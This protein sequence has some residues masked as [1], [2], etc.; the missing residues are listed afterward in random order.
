MP[1]H[2]PPAPS[3]PLPHRRGSDS[4]TNN[5]PPVWSINHSVGPQPAPLP[6]KC[7][8]HEPNR[9]GVCCK[10]LKGDDER[11]LID[12]DVVRDVVIGLSD[13]LTVP[14]ALTAGLSSLGESKLVILGGIAELIAGAISMGIGG[15][16]ATQAERDHYRY[17][18]KVTAARVLRSCDGEMEREVHAVLGPVG[19]D[20]KVS[21]QVASC[22]REVEFNSSVPS[23]EAESSSTRRAGRAST[24]SDATLISE[25]GGEL[26]WSQ[27]VGLTAFLLKFGEGLEDV[28]T[29]RMYTSAFTIG[30]GYLI[31]GLIPLLPYF[32]EP[33]AHIALIYSCVVTGVVLLIFG[34]VKA[35]VTGA[36][37]ANAGGYVWG[38][39][40]TLLVGGAAAAASYGIVAA[41]EG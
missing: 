34:A 23:D 17:L 10:E 12:P 25:E 5:K 1:E 4:L 33:V 22:L 41:L 37:G 2:T 21:R 32:F 36:A 40:S 28:S 38:A 11:T 15:F 19:V 27:D 29:I 30:M 13:G 3:V 9:S 20:E 35:R 18:R 39:V 31:G 24:A 7:D 8:R 26:R 14:F 16:L 6:A